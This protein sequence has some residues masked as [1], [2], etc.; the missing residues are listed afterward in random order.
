MR[1]DAESPDLLIAKRL[2]DYLKLQGFE[3]HR[4]APGED[5]PLMGNR[6]SD[7]WLDLSTLRAS[8]VTVSP[9][10]SDGHR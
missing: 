1:T 3:F 2:L 9:G 5:G 6:V 8:A 4:V 7:N 10:V